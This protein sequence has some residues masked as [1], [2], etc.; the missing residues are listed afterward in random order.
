MNWA[1]ELWESTWYLLNITVFLIA[2][3]KVLKTDKVTPTDALVVW[4]GVVCAIGNLIF[5]CIQL[6]GWA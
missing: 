6:K 4:G 3:F 5:L 2:L 1:A